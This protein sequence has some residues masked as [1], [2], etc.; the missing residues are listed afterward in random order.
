MAEELTRI[1]TSA[2]RR[3]FGVGAMTVLG[4][5]LLYV[6]FAEPPANWLWQVFLVA[7]GLAALWFSARMWEATGHEL[8]LTDEALTDSDG[9]ELARLDQ[10]A[11]VDRSV[12]AMKPS[13]GFIILLKEPMPR[14][15]RPGLWWRMGRRI[16]VGGVTSGAATK[17][18]ADIIA[19]KVADP[20]V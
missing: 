3:V 18:M 14:A 6:A 8:I 13:N 15:W 5:M 9:T 7:L 11:K 19:V 16:A 20:D 12:F 2:P 1:G 17:P 4:G 10:I